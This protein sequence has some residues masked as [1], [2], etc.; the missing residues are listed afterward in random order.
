MEI[1]L[2]TTALQTLEPRTQA[3]P[4]PHTKCCHLVG[5]DGTRY[6]VNTNQEV[7]PSC[8]WEDLYFL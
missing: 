4:A 7:N 3:L 8:A 1:Q 5:V 2:T 6:K